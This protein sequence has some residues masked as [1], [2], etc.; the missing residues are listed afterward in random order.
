MSTDWHD[1]T[2]RAGRCG[3]D[4]V[5]WLMWD[6]AAIRRYEELGVPDGAGWIIGWRLAPLGDVSAPAASA[7]TYSIDAGIISMVL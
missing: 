7:A 3:H 5:G 4:L 6:P 1:L 2:F